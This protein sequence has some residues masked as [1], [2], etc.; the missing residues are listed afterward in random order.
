MTLMTLQIRLIQF[1][2]I[3]FLLLISPSTFCPQLNIELDLKRQICLYVQTDFR[4]AY[5]LEVKACGG[6]GCEN[7]SKLADTALHC[8]ILSSARNRPQPRRFT[9][10]RKLGEESGSEY[11]DSEYSDSDYSY[12]DSEEY[13]DGYVN[14]QDP[15]ENEYLRNVRV[16]FPIVR[17]DPV[18][19]LICFDVRKRLVRSSCAPSLRSGRPGWGRTEATPTLSMRMASPLKQLPNSRTGDAN[20]I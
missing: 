10:P 14:G 5:V 2:H 6:L 4:D 8:N 1:E 19:M 13:S 12:S 16:S 17:L 20:K 15:E 11:S 7:F 3:E 9:P 18:R